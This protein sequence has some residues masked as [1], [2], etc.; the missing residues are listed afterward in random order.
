MPLSQNP[1]FRYPDNSIA[2]SQNTFYHHDQKRLWNNDEDTIAVY[3][4]YILFHIK[5]HQ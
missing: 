1:Q 3:Y 2:E 5:R 4:E